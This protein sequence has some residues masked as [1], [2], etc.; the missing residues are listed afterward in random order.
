MIH[1]D[2]A[3]DAMIGIRMIEPSADSPSDH[4]KIPR[5]LRVNTACRF[6]NP[7]AIIAVAIPEKVKLYIVG[8]M[9]NFSWNKNDELARYAKSAPKAKI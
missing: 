8:L 9:P 4:I 2:A 5:T 6:Q 7:T 1:S 3:E